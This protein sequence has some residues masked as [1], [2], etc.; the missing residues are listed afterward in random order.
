M[1]KLIEKLEKKEQEYASTH[2][3][4][5]KHVPVANEG[6][7]NYSINE[8]VTPDNKKGYEIKLFRIENNRKMAKSI[9]YGPEAASRTW[10]WWDITDDK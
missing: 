5:F 6:D 8:Y 2:D 3:G 7:Q 9:G 1:E 10:D 4:K